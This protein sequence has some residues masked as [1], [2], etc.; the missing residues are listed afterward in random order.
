MQTQ[1]GNEEM[2]LLIRSKTFNSHD[3]FLNIYQFTV[4]QARGDFRSRFNYP[5]QQINQA[6]LFV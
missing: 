3:I 4:E 5:F 2:I 1:T 6:Y